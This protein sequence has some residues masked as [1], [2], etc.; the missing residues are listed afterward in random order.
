MTFRCAASRTDGGLSLPLT[1]PWSRA[2][3]QNLDMLG[4]VV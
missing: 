4:L 2:S 1:A 3:F